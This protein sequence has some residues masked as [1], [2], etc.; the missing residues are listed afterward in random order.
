MNAE[1]K[2]KFSESEVGQEAERLLVQLM[3]IDCEPGRVWNEEKCLE[4]APLTLEINRLKKEKNALILAHSYVYPEI[5]YG[6]ADYRGDSY[7][8]A[9]MARKKTPE[10]IIFA[11][12]VFMAETAKILNPNVDVYVPDINSG[13]SLADSLTGDDVKALKEKYPQADVV[14]YI[15]SSAE[16]KAESDVCVTSSN[17]YDIVSRMPS[18]EILFVPDKLMAENIRLEME[19]RNIDKAIY[20]SQG[21]CIVHDNFNTDFIREEKKRKPELQ[22]VSHPECEDEVTKISD[23]VGSTGKMMDFVRESQKEEFM[24]LTECG[25]VGRLQNELPNKKFTPSCKLCPYM[26]MNALEK[27]YQALQSPQPRQRIELNQRTFDG[28]RKCIEKMF[29]MTT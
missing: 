16:V 2:N 10:L 11:G 22:I 24:L 15:N 21:T 9:D 25:L 13:C 7:F 5:I 8:L 3:N 23:F 6:V 17:V 18:K 20:S 4:L 14:C 12:V 1:M 19:K 27:I 26:K 28:A 29:E